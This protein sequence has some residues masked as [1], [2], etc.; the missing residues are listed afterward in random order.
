[1]KLIELKP[2]IM[3][4]NFDSLYI[5]TG[6]EITIMDKYIQSIAKGLNKK[7][8]RLDSL[9]DL[10]NRLNVRSFLKE[11]N[12]YILRDNTALMKEEKLWKNFST[13][14]SNTNVILV[15]SKM[16]KR[17]AF[18]KHFANI[19]VEFEKLNSFQLSNYVLKKINVNQSQAE[20]LVEFCNHDYG[21]LMLELDKIECLAGCIGCSKEEAFITAMQEDLIFRVPQQIV[22]DFSNAVICRAETTAFNILKDLKALQTKEMQ[23]LAYLYN[24]FRQVL[25]VQGV[26]HPTAEL[27]GLTGWQI[28]KA[29]ENI[30]YYRTRSI[31][32]ILKT[33]QKVESGIKMGRIDAEMALDYCLLKIFTVEE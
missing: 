27:T 31:I 20:E 25:L 11:E 2:K 15:Y 24:G 9:K 30:G 28:K 13:A 19:I 26:E 7:I 33:I 1:M 29:R 32:E 12:L 8:V 3:A 10:Y 14:V 21:R 18:Y 17:K 4:K 6:E 16:D 5:F 22:A 23:P